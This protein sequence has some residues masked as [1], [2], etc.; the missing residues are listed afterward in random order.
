MFNKINKFITGEYLAHEILMDLN[1][2]II[3]QIKSKFDKAGGAVTLEKVNN[4]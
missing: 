1:I 2:S 3:Q 4:S